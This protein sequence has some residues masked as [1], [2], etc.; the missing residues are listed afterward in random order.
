MRLYVLLKIDAALARLEAPEFT[1]PHAGRALIVLSA[2]DCA[3]TLAT[4]VFASR[5]HRRFFIKR[6][7]FRIVV[8][9]IAA[10]GIPLSV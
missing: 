7:H 6:R 3:K 8:I 4:T 9:A 5:L 1:F 10:H 2:S